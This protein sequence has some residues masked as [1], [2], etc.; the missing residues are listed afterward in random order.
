MT[1]PSK[2]ETSASST[3]DLRSDAVSRPTPAMRQAMMDAEVGDD[4]FGDDP[5]IHRLEKLSADTLAKET[6]CFVC[7]GTMSNLIAIM[8]H[9]DRG[10]EYIVGQDAHTYAYEGGGAAV[11][12]SVQPQPIE[13]SADG[14]I[15]IEKIRAAIKP[16]HAVFA[17]TRLICLENTIG[18]KVIAPEYT[19][20][21]EVLARRHQLAFHLDGAR[22]FNAAT[23]LHREAREL[24]EPFDTVS[25]CLSKGLGAPVGSV[26]CGPA[27]VI[28]RARRWRKVVGGGWRQAG[29]LAAAG[30]VALQSH[31]QRLADDHAHARHLATELDALGF[32][33]GDAH[34][35]M[36]FL[37]LDESE[38]ETIVDFMQKRGIRLFV[39]GSTLRL[40][41]HLDVSADDVD[42]VVEAFR[43][44]RKQR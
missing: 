21:V 28:A 4:V 8:A 39:R 17:K 41:T 44:F 23:A 11:L 27:P 22:L 37:T 42:K 14:T 36:V 30:I 9:C 15:P 26:L 32:D 12:G 18:G 20:D 29:L 6:A 25:I 35:N 43:D 34:T 10:D 19:R 33:V 38:R 5:T 24:A 1:S 7:S 3:I 13:N 16:D 40:V 2:T 31:V